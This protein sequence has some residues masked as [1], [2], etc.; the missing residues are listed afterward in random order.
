M[1]SVYSIEYTQ[2]EVSRDKLRFFAKIVFDVRLVEIKYDFIFFI[3]VDVERSALG[4]VHRTQGG[5]TFAIFARIVDERYCTLCESNGVCRMHA[6]GM[7]RAKKV[8]RNKMTKKHG[9][10]ELCVAFEQLYTSAAKLCP[11]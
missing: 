9:A 7:W 1:L 2:S 6:R 8:D 11:I 4:T 3:F 10:N 5:Q